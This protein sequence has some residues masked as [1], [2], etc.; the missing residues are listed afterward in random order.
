[1]T[2]GQFLIF[3]VRQLDSE[4]SAKLLFFKKHV[5]EELSGFSRSEELR[6]FFF[7]ISWGYDCNQLRCG[8]AC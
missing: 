7:D 3:L 8:M 2:C 4:Q 6:D 1:M 5:L